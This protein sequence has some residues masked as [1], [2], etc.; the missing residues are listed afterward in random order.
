MK[1]LLISFDGIDSSG[2]ET[3][4][5]LLV[6]K[7]RRT[8][9][10]VG[11][12]QTP[13]YTTV[14]GKKLKALFQGRNGSWDD[15]AWQ[16]KMKL[17][18]ANR[19]E[20]KEEVINLLQRGA[21][22]IYDRYVPSSVAHV[23][24]DAFD[25][26]EIAAKREKIRIEVENHEYGENGMPHENLSVFLDISPQEAAELLRDR[27]TRLSE[28]NEATDKIDLQSRIYQ[29]YLW[30]V[31][32]FPSRFVKVDCIVDSK[33]LSIHTIAGKV[34]QLVSTRFPDLTAEVPSLIRGG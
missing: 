5:N 2:K 26:N 7:L 16:E 19:A 3:Q 23:A 17:L 25:P 12:F 21:V 31:A 29:E 30:L 13:D 34:W 20:H 1:G 9:R 11:F 27:K 14:S 32:N 24:V 28:A 33:L 15:L 8:G 22:V 4:A 6:N 18:A 10:E